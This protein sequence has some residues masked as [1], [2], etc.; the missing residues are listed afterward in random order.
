MADI[1]FNGK[2]LET[3]ESQTKTPDMDPTHILERE[4]AGVDLK[5]SIKYLLLVSEIT[6][7]VAI[8]IPEANRFGN[9][10]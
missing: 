10:C 9:S 3:F 6:S 2:E 4:I 1:K 7:I 8:V 5:L